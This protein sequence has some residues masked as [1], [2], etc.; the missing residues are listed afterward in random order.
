MST[1]Q[2]STSIIAFFARGREIG[3]V[4]MD[5]GQIVR[6]GVKTIKGSKQGSDL[7]QRVELTLAPVLASTGLHSVIVVEGNAARL[8]GALCQAVIS[9]SKQWARQG[10]EV[11]YVSWRLLKA[12]FCGNCEA[13]YG[14]VIQAVTAWHPLLWPLVHQATAPQIAYWKKVLLAAALAEVGMVKER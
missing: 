7:V 11:R 14:A 1:K 6:Y 4:V 10:Y 8:K 12:R 5:S 9:L 13:T 2:I 3:F